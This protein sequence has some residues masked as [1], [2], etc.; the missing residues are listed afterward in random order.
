[1]KYLRFHIQ[2]WSYQFKALPFGL[3]SAPMDFTVIAKE[4]K[5]M[6]LHKSIRIGQYLND[7]LVRHRSHQVGLKHT[8]DLVQNCQK[9]CWLGNLEKSEL[10]SRQVFDFIGNQ[11]LQQKIQDLLS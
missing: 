7:W 6:A 8:Q 4:V 9:L 11:T 10:N 1:M 3:S 5:L 2:G